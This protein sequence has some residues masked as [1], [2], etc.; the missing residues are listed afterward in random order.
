MA[1]PSPLS[2]LRSVNRCA[3]EPATTAPHSNR[4][5]RLALTGL[6]QWAL[7]QGA[8]NLSLTDRLTATERIN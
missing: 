3:T 4:C 1:R 7:F 8:I 6:T 2:A 5:L